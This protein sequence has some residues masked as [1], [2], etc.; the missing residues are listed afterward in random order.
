PQNKNDEG[1]YKISDLT[2]IDFTANDYTILDDEKGWRFA[3]IRYYLIV[4]KGGVIPPK[5]IQKVK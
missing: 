3:F 2:E 1:L 5:Y 4:I